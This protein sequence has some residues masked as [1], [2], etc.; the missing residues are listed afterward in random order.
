[1]ESKCYLLALAETH[2][3][4][5]VIKQGSLDVMPLVRKYSRKEYSNLFNRHP[6]LRDY[7]SLLRNS[8]KDALNNDY[9]FE[10]DSFGG[11]ALFYR[12]LDVQ[13]PEFDYQKNICQIFTGTLKTLLK[14]IRTE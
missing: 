14:K 10:K 2:V 12:G 1:M 8:Y 3:T 6:T 13:K 11:Y 7:E 9:R 5:L 4:N